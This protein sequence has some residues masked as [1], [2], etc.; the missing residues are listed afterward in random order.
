[1]TVPDKSVA[2]VKVK[3]G[4]LD[5]LFIKGINEMNGTSVVPAASFGKDVFKAMR[6]C[7]ILAYRKGKKWETKIA[8]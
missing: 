6:S 3:G 8:V 7:D 4:D 1:V 5:S 2:V